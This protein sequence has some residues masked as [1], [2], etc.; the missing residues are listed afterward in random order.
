MRQVLTIVTW[1]LVW[2]GLVSGGA[3]ADQEA[4]RSRE[5]AT[6]EDR[7]K[8]AAHAELRAEI[9]QTLAALIEA[10]SA[11]QP[12]QARIEELTQK[13]QQLRGRMRAQ[14]SATADGWVCPRGGPGMGYGRGAGWGGQG[15]GPGGGFGP[16]AG[17]GWRGGAG[18]GRG[19]GPG[20][21]HGRAPGGPAFVDKDNN[22]VCD[23]FELR[24]GVNR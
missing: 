1:A 11:E 16:G 12:D 8:P 24:Q 14:G 2:S 9:H 4:N 15:R 19:F 7:T 22:G 3:A 5:Q 18:G 21:G 23:N 10:C 13:L 17:R 20:A 6:A